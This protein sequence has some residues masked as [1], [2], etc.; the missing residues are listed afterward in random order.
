MKI[1][2]MLLTGAMCL[3]SACGGSSDDDHPAPP[4][5]PAPPA[6]P[7]PP[8]PPPAPTTDSFFSQVSQLLGGEPDAEPQSVESSVATTPE[9][10][11][12]VAVG[13]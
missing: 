4:A 12:P 11:E 5:P 10:S 3:L 7:A 1:K 8:P 9:D 6:Q 13:S 2:L